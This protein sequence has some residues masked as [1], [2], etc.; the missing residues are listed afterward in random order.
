[1]LLVLVIG[2]VIPGG[3]NI[4]GAPGN[5][6]TGAIIPNGGGGAII[7]GP[8]GGTMLGGGTPSKG[9]RIHCIGCPV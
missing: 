7:P 8:T 4:L 6:N 2:G 9:G 3:G 1:M 5:G